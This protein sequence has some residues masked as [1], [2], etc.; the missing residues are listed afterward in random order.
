MLWKVP[1]LGNRRVGIAPDLPVRCA[2]VGEPTES[3]PGDAYVERAT[4]ACPGGLDGEQ[5]AIRGLSAT[6]LEVL[7]RITRADGSVQT[8]RLTPSAP[9][10][11][12]VAAPGLFGVAST[13]VRLGFEHILGGIDHLLFVLAL[14][15]LVGATRR[16]IATVTA[17]TV[18]HSLTLAAATLGFVHVPPRPVEAV[19]A[20]S[21][22]FVAAEIVHG[23]GGRPGLTARRPWVVAFTFGL[24]H[25]LG[26]AGALAEVGLPAQAIPTA[27]VCFNVGVELGQ[28]VFIAM[29][30]VLAGLV[31][32]IPLP[33]R[34]WMAYVPP[35]AIGAVAAYWTLARL[36]FLTR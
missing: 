3:W 15:L 9:M 10:L 24:L 34:G 13:Y 11:T 22:A 16:L 28:L 25:G 30:L 26:F 20:L 21:I 31:R 6:M 36:A 2:P 12:V 23:L 18:A 33:E 14:F 7:V 29:L 35:Y 5:V 27:L 17:F 32:R 4:L 19:I 8:A 1:A